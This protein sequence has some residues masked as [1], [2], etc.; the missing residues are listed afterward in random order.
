MKISD[1]DG[2]TQFMD[3][4]D[5]WYR[6]YIS[7][8]GSPDPDAVLT[9]QFYTDDIIIGDTFAGTTWLRARVSCSESINGVTGLY[10]PD[11]PDNAGRMSATGHLGQ[12]ETEDYKINVA[13]VPVPG[14]VWLL[15]S[16]L[17]GLLGVRRKR[18]I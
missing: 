8:N 5:N 6:D 11:D 18:K 15:G 2:T 7:N 1:E 16:G 13:P 12:G 10:N 9:K 14:A 4:D 17:L 3:H